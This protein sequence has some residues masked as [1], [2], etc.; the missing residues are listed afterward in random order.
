MTILFTIA[1]GLIIGN[2]L[3]GDLIKRNEE[4]EI[5]IKIK[6]GYYEE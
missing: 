3:Y 2:L 6:A 4:K 5:E 1:I